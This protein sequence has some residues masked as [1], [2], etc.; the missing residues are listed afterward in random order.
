[1]FL[2]PKQEVGMEILNEE[3]KRIASKIMETNTYSSSLEEKTTEYFYNNKKDIEI[4]KSNELDAKNLL[5]KGDE[6]IHTI[7]IHCYQN[8]DN[9]EY[10]K[11]YLNV[12]LEKNKNIDLKSIKKIFKNDN[13]NSGIFNYKVYLTSFT[14][15][16]NE[17]E[18]QDVNAVGRN[19]EA[20]YEI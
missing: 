14:I 12:S 16:A 18:N 5:K 3:I 6:L 10:I 8:D 2:N 11:K 13:N 15:D 9:N 20:T 19:E 1:M 7:Y 4:F 17:H